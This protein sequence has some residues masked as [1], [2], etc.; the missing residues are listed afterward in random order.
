MSGAKGG[1]AGIYNRAAYAAEKK[2]AL[3]PLGQPC[4]G[5]ARRKASEGVA[6]AGGSVD[7]A[8]QHPYSWMRRDA[9]NEY[10]E[11]I[12]EH[13]KPLNNPYP[14]YGNPEEYVVHEVQCA[15]FYLRDIYLP[16]KY[17]SKPIGTNSLVYASI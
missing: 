7:V 9:D 4:H 12:I 2:Q 15:I 8:D 1:V 13:L 17:Q 10:V 3:E 5:L 14:H 11:P 16:R 6:A